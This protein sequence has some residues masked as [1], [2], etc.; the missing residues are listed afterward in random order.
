MMIKKLCCCFFQPQEKVKFEKIE[1]KVIYDSAEEEKV[2][3]SQKERIKLLS[4]T[5]NQQLEQ[6]KSYKHKL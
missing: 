2:S 6:A 1:E 5:I 4:E 3:D